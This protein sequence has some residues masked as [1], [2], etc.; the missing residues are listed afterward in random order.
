MGT[1]SFLASCIIRDSDSAAGAHSLC[2][3]LPTCSRAPAGMCPLPYAA[4]S[5]GIP[6]AFSLYVLLPVLLWLTA[7]DRYPANAAPLAVVVPPVELVLVV[8]CVV[9]C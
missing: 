3:V 9:A 6:L 5:S 7:S 2:R 1:P 8:L 4:R